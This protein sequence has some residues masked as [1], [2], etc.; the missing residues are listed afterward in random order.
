MHPLEIEGTPPLQLLGL[1]VS[2][3]AEC[4]RAPQETPPS[5]AEGAKAGAATG[6]GAGAG[7]G[8]VTVSVSPP[9]G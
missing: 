2:D 5:A 1:R 4:G 9:S 7:A 6:A 3:Q 8:A